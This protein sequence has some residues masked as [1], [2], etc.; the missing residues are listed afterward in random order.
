MLYAIA[1]IGPLVLGAGWLYYNFWAA[2]RVFEVSNTLQSEPDQTSDYL[3][4][5]SRDEAT[6]IK[7][8]NY[9]SYAVALDSYIAVGGRD[10]ELLYEI[11]DANGLDLDQI[12]LA[13]DSETSLDQVSTVFERGAW[14][15]HTYEAENFTEYGDSTSIRLKLHGDAQSDLLP[16][17]YSGPS[18]SFYDAQGNFE[19]VNLQLDIV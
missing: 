18:F 10:Q 8:V 7:T 1:I 15:A 12:E 6:D 2:S 17:Q 4:V 9:S 14:N 13:M 19:S 11:H 3:S 5:E 16:G